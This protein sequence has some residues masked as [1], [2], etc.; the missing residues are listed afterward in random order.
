MVKLFLDG[1]LTSPATSELSFA[2]K[3]I[4]KKSPF[5]E[6]AL[7]RK[8][9]N[10]SSKTFYHQPHANLW[11]LNFQSLPKKKWSLAIGYFYWDSHRAGN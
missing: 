7:I 10:R 1:D 5:S 4:I 11:K 8:R 3:V 9:T 2:R 6:S